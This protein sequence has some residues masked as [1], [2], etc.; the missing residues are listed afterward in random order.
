M[1]GK[2]RHL[3]PLWKQS[4]LDTVFSD[5]LTLE[6]YYWGS[7]QSWS[8]GCRTCI[9]RKKCIMVIFLVSDQ[10]INFQ[11]QEVL[12]TCDWASAM[13]LQQHSEALF[14]G[15]HPVN[16][17]LCTQIKKFTIVNFFFSWYI[18]WSHVRISF[19]FLRKTERGNSKDQCSL[20][21][22]KIFA[23]CFSK[24]KCNA[25]K[26]HTDQRVEGQSRSWIRIENRTKISTLISSIWLLNL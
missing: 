20:M 6:G 18:F 7:C 4:W 5:Q 22:W 10:K 2:S 9:K 3:S 1:Q 12:A 26:D 23:V 17:F 13:W 8:H 14:S 21:Q 16:T 25:I 19:S 24:P 11:A 15:G